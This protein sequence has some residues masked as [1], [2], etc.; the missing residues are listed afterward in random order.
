MSI[1]IHEKKCKGC[2]LCIAACPYGEIILRE[3]KAV[4]TAGCTSCGACI[5]SCPHGAIAFE[6]VQERVHMDVALFKG[7]YVFV[8]QDHQTASKVSLEL[9]GR[10]R[11]L[12]NEYSKLGKN[13]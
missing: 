3:K 9:L 2:K 13:R 8:E 1:V 11:G 5:D 6:G 7:I 10:A 12:A 4:L